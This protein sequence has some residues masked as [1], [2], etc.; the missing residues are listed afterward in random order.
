[1]RFHIARRRRRSPQ[2]FDTAHKCFN[3]HRIFDASKRLDREMRPNRLQRCGFSQAS[4]R[5]RPWFAFGLPQ[6]A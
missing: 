5:L 1:L 6:G 3:Q 2:R 4:A